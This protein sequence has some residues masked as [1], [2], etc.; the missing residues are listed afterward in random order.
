M[1]QTTQPARNLPVSIHYNN[2]D[3][4]SPQTAVSED[5]VYGYYLEDQLG[6]ETYISGSP[7]HSKGS[8]P[9]HGCE[10]ADQVEDEDE[11]DS[12]FKTPEALE[13]SFL[14]Y[15]EGKGTPD[16]KDLKQAAEGSSPT[17]R[18]LSPSSLRNS[19]RAAGNG[20]GSGNFEV[21]DN[22]RDSGFLEATL[23]STSRNRIGTTGL[24]AKMGQMIGGTGLP[25][26][27]Q[28][29]P[30]VKL[31]VSTGPACGSNNEIVNEVGEAYDRDFEVEDDTRDTRTERSEV[32]SSDETES[33]FGSTSSLVTARS[34]LSGGTSPS[35]HDL[36]RKETD[37]TTN[38]RE[39]IQSTLAL[40]SMART[41]STSFEHNDPA[42]AARVARSSRLNILA[43]LDALTAMNPGDIMS[44]PNDSPR[45]APSGSPVTAAWDG[46]GSANARIRDDY[47]P[48]AIANGRTGLSAEK[49]REIEE[50]FD[51]TD[52]NMGS[53][54]GG[55]EPE[56]ADDDKNGTDAVHQVHFH[57]HEAKDETVNPRK[58]RDRKPP[59]QDP[60]PPGVMAGTRSFEVAGG[61][62]ASVNQHA[63]E[64]NSRDP[65]A[66]ISS[67]A[68]SKTPSTRNHTP[69]AGRDGKR[70]PIV[71]DEIQVSRDDHDRKAEQ[72][73]AQAKED[74]ASH[75]AIASH[76]PSAFSRG[77]DPAVGHGKMS[78]DGVNRDQHQGTQAPKP[79]SEAVNF[80]EARKPGT[81]VTDNGGSTTPVKQVEDQ[82]SKVPA[83]SGPPSPNAITLPQTLQI[84]WD[85]TLG[86]RLGFG[87]D[88]FTH[89]GIPVSPFET[90][91]SA[92]R[93]RKISSSNTVFEFIDSHD[94]ST[95]TTSR[96]FEVSVGTG[97]VQIPPIT[98]EC[99]ASV[100]DIVLRSSSQRLFLVHI[101]CVGLFEAEYI[102]AS[103]PIKK[104]LN[105]RTSG[106]GEY[107]IAGQQAGYY[108]RVIVVCQTKHQTLSEEFRSDVVAHFQK[109]VSGKFSASQS[110]SHSSGWTV[111]QT[112][113][114]TRGCKAPSIPI[115]SSS[116]NQQL[117]TL[118]ESLL[119]VSRDA[120]G[121]P[122]TAIL[123][124]YSTLDPIFDRKMEGISRETFDR[125]H[126]MRN[127]YTQLKRSLS[128]PALAARSDAHVHRTEVAEAIK[129]FEH[130]FDKNRESLQPHLQ[131]IS[132]E[133][134][135]AILRRLVNFSTELRSRHQLEQLVEKNNEVR[136]SS[137]A[138]GDQHIFKWEC[139]IS[140][141][142]KHL[143]DDHGKT[144]SKVVNVFSNRDAFEVAW[145]SRTKKPSLLAR[146][147]R[148]V[149]ICTPSPRYME[150][151]SGRVDPNVP[152]HAGVHQVQD[153]HP[154][155]IIRWEVTCAHWKRR[156]KPT[157]SV[158]FD[159]P[160]KNGLLAD[161]A[162]IEI[163]GSGTAE[164]KC[165]VTYVPT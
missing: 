61:S 48:E 140:S 97:N 106:F 23:G 85:D 107:Y 36:G 137:P 152:S 86:H 28:R 116:D 128:D 127:H 27:R 92:G 21:E 142:G 68:T 6:T 37:G 51:T 147:L 156:R 90:L 98:A 94:T 41:I 26:T 62:N 112:V 71:V 33:H 100:N 30:K 46:E 60:S 132:Y 159:S 165:T 15:F 20:H 131:Q 105:P 4:H 83:T 113:T 158:R 24:L 70:R 69:S 11:D 57:E 9:D 120:P 53:A 101:L 130:I 22:T 104:G 121:T 95:F 138:N 3:Q 125:V 52:G 38:S 18:C 96:G 78:A 79:L 43:T 93:E 139:G 5:S 161:H 108:C 148:R 45:P 76:P 40:D 146:L 89:R 118:S 157:P 81:G 47:D 153:D 80:Q 32:L 16:S 58:E 150:F 135:A 87:V 88:A 50:S 19:E 14:D 2:N 49:K 63:R 31:C 103:T 141:A 91:D 64:K 122:F 66:P 110:T 163:D 149:G 164:W 154:V 73:Q 44:S 119:S 25:S 155:Q 151:R 42:D 143:R 162:R 39:R 77:S 10:A 1:S 145:T 56:L 123:H 8:G 59:N 133:P 74:I 17:G 7:A 136:Q 35:A 160:G 134:M 84:P 54:C 13:S 55:T 12:N 114:E 117:E 124:H 126:E 144:A 82:D 129:N 102:S 75:N 115:A 72:S 29:G 99:G 67:R 34:E 65:K 109:V 111:L